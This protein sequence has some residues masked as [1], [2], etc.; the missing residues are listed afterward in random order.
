MILPRGGRAEGGACPSP[1]VWSSV[2]RVKS[3]WLLGIAVAIAALVLPAVA[4]GAL[5]TTTTLPTAAGAT[6]IVVTV[7]GIGTVPAR[8]RPTAVSVVAGGATYRLSKVNNRRWRSAKLSARA[9]TRLR[10]LKG[11]RVTV[12]IRSKAGTRSLRSVLRVPAATG[13]G[14]PVTPPPTS[15]PPA[16]PPPSL[17][18]PPG[19][20]LEGNAAFD[21][22][23]GYFLGSRFTDCA[24]LWPTCAV[25]QR[26]N[27]CPDG[28]W[29]YY[30]LT[31]VSGSDINSFGAIQQI[32][33][34]VARTDGSWGV[35]YL[36]SAYS[37]TSFYSWNVAANGT[38]TGAY[39]APGN[40]PPNPP[41]ESIGP[42]VWQG[43]ITCTGS[44]Y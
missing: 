18:T 6:R 7:N 25:E 34:A 44:P 8:Q 29:E 38:V 23:K 42:M 27:H 3:T 37:Q 28:A 22:I 13:G 39:W 26:Y 43:P 32:T 2:A 40:L 1:V 20:D 10:A 11:T 24:G 16:T 15:P 35:E 12:R 31:P 14:T 30:R 9:V 41:S 17:F 33:G 4:N 5:S 36:L 21:H 19:S